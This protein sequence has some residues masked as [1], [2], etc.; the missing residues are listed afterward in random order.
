LEKQLDDQV[1]RGLSPKERTDIFHG[2]VI[3]I[4]NT[5]CSLDPEYAE[6]TF[7]KQS[8]PIFQEAAAFIAQGNVQAA[9][10]LVTSKQYLMNTVTFCGASISVDKAK[11]LGLEVN[12]F[13]DLVDKGKE[14][15]KVKKGKCVVSTCPTRPG[16]VLVGPCNVCMDRCQKIYDKGGDPTKMGSVTRNITTL[17]STAR[18]KPSK[19]NGS[20]TTKGNITFTYA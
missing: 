14:K 17:L 9:Q 2:E 18:P 19:P 5:I 10:E 16:E 3:R 8:V 20:Q 7:G 15:W 11:E 6:A 4:L 13:G 12:S 1:R